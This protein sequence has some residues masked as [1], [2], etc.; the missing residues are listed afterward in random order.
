MRPTCGWAELETQRNYQ[1]YLSRSG[2][3]PVLKIDRKIFAPFFLCF[4]V[5]SLSS[6][7]LFGGNPT[8]RLVKAPASKQVYTEPETG[9]SDFTTL[10]PAL[11]T[12]QPS[13]SAISMIFT[14]LVSLNDKL[15]VQPQLAQT[16]SLGNDGLTWTFHLKAKL[17]FSDGKPLTASDVI[18]S[19]DRA[20]DRKSVV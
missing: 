20:L 14:G 11:A 12:V 5:L 8:I 10:D 19:L 9:I 17:K 2:K 15:E 16:W 1:I 6:C 18:Y 7:T 3:M 4:I 13:T